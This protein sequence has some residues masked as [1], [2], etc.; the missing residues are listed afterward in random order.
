MRRS[1]R[2]WFSRAA[3][4]GRRR[5]ARSA[6]GIE[7]ACVAVRLAIRRSTS[8]RRG[9]GVKNLK[10]PK[11]PSIP[12]SPR[13]S[14]PRKPKGLAFIETGREPTMTKRAWGTGSAEV[15][16]AA[17]CPV[18]PR[19]RKRAASP[20]NLAQLRAYFG[21]TT[22]AMPSL[23]TQAVERE[24]AAL[25]AAARRPSG[26]VIALRRRGSVSRRGSRIPAFRRRRKSWVAKGKFSFV[27][28][29]S[30][31]P[32]NPDGIVPGK[33]PSH[34]QSCKLARNGVRALKKRVPR[35]D[36][37]V[38]RSAMHTGPAAKEAAGMP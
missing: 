9:Q 2:R 37:A 10:Q 8:R 20:A 7:N 17:R 30:S 25:A 29:K 6:I 13:R 35:R 34:Q 32:C 21:W 36:T 24:E 16:S 12:S 33:R 19:L 5:R 11:T 28:G 15:C 31:L 3:S 1:P 26:E 4:A 23:Y 18:R 14:R 27:I 22:D 38:C